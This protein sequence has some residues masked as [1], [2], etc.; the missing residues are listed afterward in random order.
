M[1]HVV[2]IRA[3]LRDPTALAD[4][5]TRLGLP[6]PQAGTARLFSAQETGLLV[7]FPGWHYP[8]VVQPELGRVLFDT[9]EG[10]W[11]DPA[12]LDRL[13][14]AYAVAKATRE[15]RRTGHRVVEQQLPD[16]SIRLTL[17]AGAGGAR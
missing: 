12:W 1:S 7:R 5:C 11:G 16:G 4:A 17:H 9:Y 15:A 8:A 14:Q 6:T 3:E 13:Q 10:R 2:T